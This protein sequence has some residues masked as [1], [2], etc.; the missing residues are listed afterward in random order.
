MITQIIKKNVLSDVDVILK[1]VY[2]NIYQASLLAID[3]DIIG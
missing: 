2:V 1:Y 3:K